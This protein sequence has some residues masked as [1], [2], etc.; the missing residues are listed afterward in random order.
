MQNKTDE[1]VKYIKEYKLKNIKFAVAKQALLQKGYTE[2][3][4]SNA[5]YV[6]PYDET[7]PKQTKNI[8][9]EFYENNP[10]ASKKVATSLLLEDEQ[11]EMQKKIIY[12]MAADSGT[13]QSS[14]YYEVRLADEIG[15]PY[16]TVF[17]LGILFIVI[18]EIYKFPNELVNFVIQA[19]G[20]IAS[21]Y[22]AFKYI[23]NWLTIRKLKKQQRE[24]RAKDIKSVNKNTE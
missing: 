1:I 2:A 6:E 10:Q 9:T 17:F 13:I 4:I 7:K 19:V 21:V 3:E 23:Q 20:F 12:G 5:L 8:V 11:K 22:C 24:A 14:S 15:W 16:Y 18:A